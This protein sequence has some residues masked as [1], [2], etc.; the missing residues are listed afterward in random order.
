MG[1]RFRKSFGAG[2]FRVNLS[3]SG[4]GWSVGGKGAR[5]TKKVNS[6]TRTTLSVPGTGLSYV[7]ET[8]KKKNKKSKSERD[9]MNYVNSMSATQSVSQS[10]SLIEDPQT[11]QAPSK[12]KLNKKEITFWVWVA[13][14]CTPITSPFATLA[15][16]FMVPFGI[17]LYIKRSCWRKK[18]RM[19]KVPVAY[20]EWEIDSTPSLSRLINYNLTAE[21]I[22]TYAQILEFCNYGEDTDRVF[23][24][25][26]LNRTKG[27]MISNYMMNKLYE[28]GFLIKPVKGK[29]ALNPDRVD[30]INANYNNYATATA[31]QNNYYNQNQTYNNQNQ[32]INN[33]NINNNFTN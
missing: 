16:F 27:T 11:N 9:N 20:E 26:E 33:S 28:F 2:P 25:A 12:R 8:S 29:F 10:Y 19:L 14:F 13:C 4:V 5:Y 1:F 30:E 7:S 23:D 24:L 3:K 18:F 32:N 15:M 31:N 17:Y 21:Q 22:T 6:G